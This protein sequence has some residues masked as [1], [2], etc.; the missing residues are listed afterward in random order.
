MIRC[1]LGLGSNLQNPAKQLRA[2]IQHL[3]Q[4]PDIVL[5]AISAVYHSRA[6]G[7]GEQP[8]YLNAAAAIDTRLAPEQLLEA[9]QTIERA[10]GRV[11][12]ERWGART[13]DID[14]LLYGHQLIHSEHLRIPHPAMKERRFVLQPLADIFP[15]G[16]VL[17][18]G[19]LPDTLLATCRTAA[20]QRA[21]I[22]L[23]ITPEHR[24]ER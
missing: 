10:Q 16:Q 15:K 6:V 1:Y 20:L 7:P 24:F 13:L 22:N 19:E 14:I 11:R 23:H 2:A 12:H 18:T 5:V 3:R 17:P 9:L 21:D 8:D 4:I